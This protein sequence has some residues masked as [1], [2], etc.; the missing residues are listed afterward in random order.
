ML[1]LKNSMDAKNSFENLENI[2]FN[3][4]RSMAFSKTCFAPDSVHSHGDTQ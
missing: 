4:F 3:P 2:T 1:L